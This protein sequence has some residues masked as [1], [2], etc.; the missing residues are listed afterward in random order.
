MEIKRLFKDVATELR[1]NSVGVS[2]IAESV[3]S[4]LIHEIYADNPAR[5]CV[6][7]AQDAKNGE[8]I[9]N[10]LNSVEAD[11]AKFFPQANNIPYNMRSVFGPTREQRMVVLN[12]ILD[13]KA[14]IVVMPVSTVFEQVAAPDKLFNSVLNIAVGEDLSVDVLAQKLTNA[15]F[16][17]E[18]MITAPGQYSKRGGIFD[19]YAFGH[20]NPIR[21]EF[22]GDTIDS[23]REF[24]IFKQRSVKPVSSVNILPMKEFSPNVDERDLAL[25]KIKKYCE[26]KRIDKKNY[27]FIAH[28]WS[29]FNEIDGLEW[30]F[31]WFDIERVGIFD[32][33]PS[34]CLVIHNDIFDLG[35][36]FE[37][38]I[39]NY[40]TRKASVPE[41]VAPFVSAP[42]DL[43]VDVSKVYENY[44]FTRC[45]LN[46]KVANIPNFVFDFI[47]QPSFGGDFALFMNDLNH[48]YSMGFDIKI[49]AENEGYANRL[50]EMLE[51]KGAKIPD[52]ETLFLNSG[53]FSL[54][55]KIYCY[56]DRKIFDRAA[57]KKL[58]QKTAKRMAAVNFD[59]LE[60]G[61]IVVHIDHGIGK[62]LGVDK[63]KAGEFEQDC[64][65]IE[66][67][68]KAFLRVPI[69][70]YYKV[71]KY[72]GKDG[73]APELSQLGSAAW[74]RRKERTREQLQEMAGKMV[75]LYAKR[76]INDGLLC[77]DDNNWQK[78][79]EASFE[80]EP[81]DDQ[82]TVIEQIKK[83][84]LDKKPM[85]RLVCGDVGFGKT[86]VAMRA[87]FK[88]VMS[89]FQVAVLA[90]TTV[91]AAQHT[92]TFRERMAEFPVKI[93]DLSRLSEAKTVGETKE[94]IAN[95]DIDILIG[96]HKIL[97]KDI[98]FKN[99]GLLIIDE[100]QRFGVKQKDLFT[101]YR[102]SINVL[103]M[104]AT[105][106]PR[107]LH[108]SMAGIRD[109]SLINT[110]PRNRLSI[111][112]KIAQSHDDL[113][114]IA[115]ENELERGGQA[116][117]VLNRIDGLSTLH[118]RIENLVPDARIVVAHGQME[119]EKIDKIMEKFV[120]GQYDVLICTTI[121]ENG[122][123]IPN[124]NTI[125]VEDSDKL[126]LSQLYQLRGRVGRSIQQAFAYFL[127]KDFRTVKD[128]SMKRLKALEQ[129]TDLGSGFQLAMRDLE[130]RGAG[131]LLG[132]DQSG[133]I[134]AV[135]FELY[136]QLLKEEISRL[137][138][139]ENETQEA[140]DTQMRIK[141]H[142]YFPSDYVADTS[143]QIMLY[144][145]C[146]S[147]KSIDELGDFEAEITDRFGA[148]PEPVGELLLFM[149]IKILAG[150]LSVKELILEKN[151]LTL[152]LGGAD[153]K[154]AKACSLF[155]A[156]DD[157]KFALDYGAQ[158]KLTS[159]IPAGD[160]LAQAR[161]AMGLLAEVK[162]MR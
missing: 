142:G 154:Q 77:N 140:I 51:E 39:S 133:S 75:K 107:T 160:P 36:I 76:E 9:C 16:S 132:T 86:E 2:G 81:T 82:I 10:E 131:N 3:D 17:R 126:G 149:G 27:D 35:R 29:V 6:V 156:Y 63:V 25:A 56:C 23:I 44:N 22:W 5:L 1:K 153:E 89:G 116:F 38:E 24:D 115:L 8:R 135:G 15:G 123:D 32:Y 100:E 134:S 31:H 83:D 7:L 122:I 13:G 47:N 73:F 96:T 66:Y 18:S 137:K 84:L 110:P 97:A 60:R 11:C 139:I 162:R 161:A 90:P 49:F 95:G 67:R 141:I 136:C 114:K 33:F 143:L 91:L 155:M 68:D 4:L 20:E 12:E 121:I 88:A 103:S 159:K 52:V 50:K 80:Y 14:K 150:I 106:I 130:L 158:I 157:K 119:G 57:S 70:D 138:N 104:S 30:F 152:I 87:A 111:E 146:T 98:V 127:V 145:K 78:E 37:R 94:K 124:A 55:Q 105:P 21:I 101:N 151:E 40:D 72:I 43:L 54:K 64:L 59:T 71:Q 34:D 45:F 28:S 53:F 69:I 61:D 112:T 93:Q 108:M 74:Q 46:Q 147:A 62:Y 148:Y 118:S 120:A 48:K 85:D 99:L 92:K 144:Q 109:L 65:L 113:I 125:I 117:V 58:A 42:Q 102:Y 79:F 19:I 26:D 128:E 41:I 129:Y